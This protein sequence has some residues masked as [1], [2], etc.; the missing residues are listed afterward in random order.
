MSAAEELPV[1]LREPIPASE[2]PDRKAVVTELFNTRRAIAL[3]EAEQLKALKER[4]AELE[5]FLKATLEVGEKVSYAGIGSVSM[6]EETQPSVTD[7]EA[8]YEYIKDNDAFYFLQR[9][10][11]AA[12]F[13][14]LLS[15]GE[16]LVGVSPIQVRKI[17]VR[18]N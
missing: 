13:R 17:S 11:N 1:E 5:N 2:L 9:K 10:I 8:L 12:P 7:W 6:A 15:T 14:E 18:K 3:I 16:S 4:K